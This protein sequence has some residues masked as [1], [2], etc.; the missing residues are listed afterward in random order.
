MSMALCSGG[1]MGGQRFLYEVRPDLF[2]Q[3]FLTSAELQLWVK[4]LSEQKDKK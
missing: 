2:P 1:G 3:G 4:F